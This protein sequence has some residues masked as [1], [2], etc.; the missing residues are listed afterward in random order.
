[1]TNFNLAAVK[2]E[3]K[4]LA[5]LPESRALQRS[6]K[7]GDQVICTKE[8]YFTYSGVEGPT[9]SQLVGDMIYVNGNGIRPDPFNPERESVCDSVQGALINQAP[10]DH[11]L[12]PKGERKNRLGLCTTLN[13]GTFRLA[14]H[15]DPGYLD[16]RE[17]WSLYYEILLK[18][19]RAMSFLWSSAALILLAMLLTGMAP[20]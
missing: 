6:I 2:A 17:G 3:Q 11:P 13:V 9:V 19:E 1:M 5:D 14:T 8:A 20:K 12:K 4:A 16:T 18:K 7:R 10:Y 15:D